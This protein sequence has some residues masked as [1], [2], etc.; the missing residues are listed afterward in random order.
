MTRLSR[1]IEEGDINRPPIAT[2]QLDIVKL[3]ASFLSSKDLAT[4]RA[5]STFFSETLRKTMLERLTDLPPGRIIKSWVDR[6]SD[7]YY[8]SDGRLYAW[9]DNRYGQ[10][11]HNTVNLST[12]SGIVVDVHVRQFVVSARSSFCVTERGVYSWGRNDLGQCGV[13]RTDLVT[14]T[15]KIEALDNQNVQQLVAFDESIF[16]VTDQGV[17]AWGDNRYGQCG[18]VGHDDDVRTPTRI[19]AL[20]NLNVRQLVN[21]DGSLFCVADQG[22][23]AWGDNKFGELGL[24]Q[25][26]LCVTR[27]TRIEA[28]DNQ[29]VQ[30]LIICDRSFFWVTDPSFFCV[31]DQGVYA[32]GYND[33]GELGLGHHE[34]CV[35]RP[36]RIEAL[37]NLNARQ[38]NTSSG[39]TFCVTDR[40]VYVWG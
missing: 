4:L 16:C 1:L 15:R 31:T 19:E 10:F 8:L 33:F 36:T 24:G 6:G 23:Y 13:G 20:N 14:R 9:G 7:T 39:S 17:Y 32:W 25:P 30:Q 11:R 34:R 5:V 35:T 18:L 22:V 40:G 21:L 38:L 2:L 28:F 26:E 29:I 27:P 3:L 37:N 12:P